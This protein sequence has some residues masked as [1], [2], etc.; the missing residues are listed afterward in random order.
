LFSFLAPLARVYPVI[1]NST[2]RSF[3]QASHSVT[4]CSQFA[5]KAQHCVPFRYQHIGVP[6]SSRT[7][8]R[9]TAAPAFTLQHMLPRCFLSSVYMT[10]ILGTALALQCL[11]VGVRVVVLGI[12]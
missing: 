1:I 3:L 10:P 6:F 5:S 4:Q 7:G 12:G 11:I 8:R 2:Q 9:F